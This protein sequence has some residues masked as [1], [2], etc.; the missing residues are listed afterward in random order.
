ME[1]I[2]IIFRQS[3]PGA[4]KIEPIYV[5]CKG[6]ETVSDAI[7]KYRI[8]SG[9]NDMS[10]KFVLNARTLKNLSLTISEVG[11]TNNSNIFVISTRGI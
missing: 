11:A 5:N 1:D 9:D 4:P 8:K 10:K 2:T 3:G 6:N 7:E